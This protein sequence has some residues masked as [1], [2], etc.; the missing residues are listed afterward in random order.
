MTPAETLIAGVI[1]LNPLDRGT[2]LR[3]K[4]IDIWDGPPFGPQYA[5]YER[6]VTAAVAIRD[7]VGDDERFKFGAKPRR[8]SR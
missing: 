7:C 5:A 8:F 4:M 2:D 3:K 1:A 6:A